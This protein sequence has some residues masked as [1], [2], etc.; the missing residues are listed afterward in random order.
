MRG[1]RAPRRI[2]RLLG[3]M[4]TDTSRRGAGLLVV[5]LALGACGGLD[6]SGSDATPRSDA[7][8][9]GRLVIVGGALDADNA[10]VWDAVLAARDGDGPVCVLPTASGVPERS[11]ASAVETLDRYG[12]PGTARGIPITEDVPSDALDPDVVATLRSC[13]G[14][15][16]TGGSQS[17][18]TETFLPD[19]SPTPALEAIRERFREGAVLAGTSAGAA[20]MSAPMIAGGSSEEAFR[21]WIDVDDGASGEGVRIRPGLAFFDVGVLDQHFL[22]RG[23]IGRLLVAVLHHPEISVGFGIDENTAMVVDGRT[24]AV[25]G[26][27][28]VVVVDGREGDPADRERAL[29]IWLAGPRD[30][31][32]LS[33]LTVEPASAKRPLPAVDEPLPE[34]PILDRWVFSTTL[35]AFSGRPE[36]G[37][38][39]EPVEGVLMTVEKGDGFFAVTDGPPA[40]GAQDTAVDGE[41]EIGAGRGVDEDDGVTG[42]QRGFA[43]GP[44]RV[45]VQ[46]RR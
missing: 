10:P 21:S 1:S 2:E 6:G 27:S 43:A 44:F 24:A 26:T 5:L 19:G 25:V 36:V 28:G 7:A 37:M 16:F 11:M 39:A 20:M 31:I 8:P 34:D 30:G 41:R 9:T 33:T 23:R 14:Y 38:V 35:A 45:R 46:E 40:G 18:I 17:R 3:R 42:G 4:G 12:G 29:T 32:D 15:W 13:S 22:A